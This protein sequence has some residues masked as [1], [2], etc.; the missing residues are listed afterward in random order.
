MECSKCK[1]DLTWLIKA[2]S[3]NSTNED[4]FKAVQVTESCTQCRYEVRR[5]FFTNGCLERTKNV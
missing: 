4:F 5:Y 3:Q 2:I 1:T